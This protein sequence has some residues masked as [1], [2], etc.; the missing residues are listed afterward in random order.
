MQMVG[1]RGIGIL[2]Q[3]CTALSRKPLK[4]GGSCD[5]SLGKGTT[6]RNPRLGRS[7]AGG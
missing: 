3:M 2:Q 1:L 5:G 4:V 6:I 7:F